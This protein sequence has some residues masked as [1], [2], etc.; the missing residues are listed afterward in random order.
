MVNTNEVIRESHQTLADVGVVIP[1]PLP[2]EKPL[3]TA[4][5]CT[6]Y[7]GVFDTEIAGHQAKLDDLTRAKIGF[8]MGMKE[9]LQ[10]LSD[11]GVVQLILE[12]P[13]FNGQKIREQVKERPFFPK[14]SDLFE[15]IATFLE[16]QR[17]AHIVNAGDALLPSFVA[18]YENNVTVLQAK[19]DQAV[20]SKTDEAVIS[21]KRA[22]VAREKQEIQ[23]LP[24][25]WAAFLASVVNAYPRAFE[26][27]IIDK[28]K[29]PL[30]VAVNTSAHRDL[31]QKHDLIPTHPL[32]GFTWDIA[33][34]DKI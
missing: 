30:A 15:K 16:E 7:S 6:L 5:R 33:N 31:W 2:G 26:P 4:I 14:S 34:I 13:N 20:E 28:D 23:G 22:L 8:E 18:G 19:L 27:N 9:A 24:L 32:S 12:T 17:C 29:N 1:S 3:G 21:Q 11:A 10:H 25:R